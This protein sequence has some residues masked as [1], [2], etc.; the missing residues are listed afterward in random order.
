MSIKKTDLEIISELIKENENIT[1]KEMA[2]AINKS[3]RTVQR[4][5]IKHG[6]IK[7]IDFSKKN[8]II[9]IWKLYL[10]HWQ[11]VRP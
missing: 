8:D 9:I 7:Y 2:L 6:K 4:I 5:I 10:F 3:I 11:N 1:I